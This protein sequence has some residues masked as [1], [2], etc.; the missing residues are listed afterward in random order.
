[1]YQLQE[2]QIPKPLFKQGELP[3]AM[4]LNYL[5]NRLAQND[6]ILLFAYNFRYTREKLLHVS[7][8]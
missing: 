5:N 3:T 6:V 8:V 4:L 2:K 7:I 1:M